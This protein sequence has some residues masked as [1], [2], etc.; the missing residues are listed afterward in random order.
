MDYTTLE[1]PLTLSEQDVNM[2]LPV[3]SLYETL[4][5]VIKTI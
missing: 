5:A 4:Q 3:Y 2:L 1:L